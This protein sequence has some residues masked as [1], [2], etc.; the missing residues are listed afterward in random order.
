MTEP[1]W[2]EE[3]LEINKNTEY[4]G[5]VSDGVTEVWRGIADYEEYYQVSNF[6]R[7]RSLDRVG[8][9]GRVYKGVTRALSDNGKGY[10]HV[11]LKL[12]GKGKSLYVHRAVATAFLPNPENKP[13]VNHKDLNTS[14]NCVTNLEWVT[15]AENMQH[16]AMFGNRVWNGIL[17]PKLK[18]ESNP[19][20]KLTDLQVVEIRKKF[21]PR[22]YTRKMLAEEYNVKETTI[23]DVVTRKSWKHLK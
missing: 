7:I 9:N 4:L 11:E 15:R 19:C 12:K 22:V 2:M 1:N 14:N 6:G 8:D 17:P 10:L 13:E 16:S 18:G 20:S 3:F 23:K 21:K 5:L